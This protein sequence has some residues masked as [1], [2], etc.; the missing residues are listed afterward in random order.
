[1]ARNIL[2]SGNSVVDATT[3]QTAIFQP[4]ANALVLMSVAN[5]TGG[6]GGGA[7]PVPT[8]TGNGLTWEQ[9]QTVTIGA[10][11]DRRL[12]L[13]RSMGAAPS[14][15]QAAISF[16]EQAQDYCAWS[17][18]EYTD[19]DT[20]GAAGQSAIAQSKAA[21]GTGT[22]LTV[23]LTPSA[24]PMRNVTVGAIMLELQADPARQ[25]TPGSGFTEIHEQIPNQFLGRGAT[26]QTQDATTALSQVNWSWTG[27]EN[28]AAI[29]LEIKAPPLPGTAPDPNE[30]LVRRFEPVLFFHPE[31][32]FF[33]VDAKRYIEHAALW[34]A[35]SSYDDKNNWGGNLGDPFPRKPMVMAGK[36][37]AV[38]GE[39]DEYL[40]KA[41]YLVDGAGVER[42]LELGGW[43]TK[44]ETPEADVTSGSGNIYADRKTIN[45]QYNDVAALKASQFWYHAEVFDTPRLK[46][47]ADRVKQPDLGK[48]VALLHNPVLLCYYL[49]FAAHEQPT[50]DGNC[51]NTE[52]K[53]V[54][55]HAGDW[56]CIAIMLDAEGGDLARARPQFFGCTG[57][58]PG[59]D[60]PHQFDDENRMVMK[61]EAWRPAFG[62]TTRLPE[63]TGD[64]PRLYVSRGSHSL[65]M[66]SG[67]QTVNRYLDENEPT[68]CGLYDSP[69]VAP[70]PP[71]PEDTTVQD[72][73]MLAKLAAGLALGGIG[74]FAGLVAAFAEYMIANIGSGLIL[75]VAR[76]E[77]DRGP[78]GAGAGRTVRPAGVSVPDGGTDV[79]DWRAGTLT[80]DGRRYD[81]LVDRATQVWWPADNPEV[82]SFRGRWGQRVTNDY[83]PRRAGPR[84]PDFAMMFLK[85]LSYG[86]TRG[87]L[88]L[89]D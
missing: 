20:V 89:P 66:T 80:L 10:T 8:V 41:E 17:V 31:E 82:P 78:A 50:D 29:V 15:G 86:D 11:N 85:A 71:E 55:C 5:A 6:L 14:A 47:L 54:G 63:V 88:R 42:F 24:D 64:H 72:G 49:F 36:L 40:G 56:Q 76:D 81:F 68:Y 25:I 60:R 16:G 59:V 2:T 22:A 65:W 12:T 32:A 33:P 51:R 3:F 9:L 43:K 19:V 83:L 70:P 21:T 30:T 38:D 79:V 46:T 18:F 4:G 58:R 48:I 13:F 52:A 77:P 37:G 57:V 27:S 75:V 45:D 73:A 39:N 53:E 7:S 35:T 44:L 26:L 23:D 69:S 84:F 1:M 62:P 34:A 67:N 28:A 87:M 61:V 74:V